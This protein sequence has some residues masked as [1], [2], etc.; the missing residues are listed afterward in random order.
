[1][2]AVEKHGLDFRQSNLAGADLMGMYLIDAQLTDAN[3]S[4]AKLNDAD[5]RGADLRGAVL[6]GAHVYKADVTNAI[7][8]R[9]QLTQEAIGQLRGRERVQWSDPSPG[10][11]TS[12][13]R[14]LRWPSRR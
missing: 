14:M 9:G 6:S 7:L 2:R 1:V 8:E 12:P 3:L 5:M 13:P 10:P 4:G 11:A